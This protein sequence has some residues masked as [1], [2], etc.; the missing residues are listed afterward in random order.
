MTS[1]IKLG[2]IVTLNRDFMDNPAGTKGYV[3]EEYDIGHPGVSVITED[4]TNLG[5]FSEDEFQFLTFERSSGYYYRFKNAIQLDW[6]FGELIAPLFK[7]QEASAN[8]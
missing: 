6:D 2:D 8:L 7:E 5:G 3:Y 1:N 4:G